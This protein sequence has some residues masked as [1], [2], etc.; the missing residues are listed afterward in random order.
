MDFC[1]ASSRKGLRESGINLGDVVLVTGT[2]IAP[3]KRSDPYLQ[4]VYVLVMKMVDNVLQVPKDDNDY[5]VVLVDPRHLT[6]LNDEKQ[7]AYREMIKEQ[8]DK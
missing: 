2:K 6:K 1:V 5:K 4:R 3:E 7:E 8:Y